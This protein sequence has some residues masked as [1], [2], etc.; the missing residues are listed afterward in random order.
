MEPIRHRTAAGSA[1]TSY[2]ATTAVPAVGASS[3][4]SIRRLVD[5]VGHDVGARLEA[6]DQPLVQ[7]AALSAL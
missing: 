2:P 6:A 3:V 4:V 7:A 1:T 5:F